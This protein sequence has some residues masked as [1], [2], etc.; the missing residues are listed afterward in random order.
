MLLDLQ[1]LISDFQLQGKHGLNCYR[2][3]GI[4][5]INAGFEFDFF[6][7]GSQA[8]SCS[9]RYCVEIEGA[10]KKHVEAK[11]SKGEG[12]NQVG[13]EDTGCFF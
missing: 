7:L 9:G 10:F 12:R 2:S 4:N 1:D 3:R 8:T 6:L 11:C 13:Y 5:G